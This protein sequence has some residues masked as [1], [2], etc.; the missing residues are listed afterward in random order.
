MVLGKTHPRFD[1]HKFF[2][3]YPEAFKLIYRQ[4]DFMKYRIVEWDNK[5]PSDLITR[6]ELELK[7]EK[8]QAISTQEQRERPVNE[9][10]G[11]SIKVPMDISSFKNQAAAT[12]VQMDRV[13]QFPLIFHQAYKYLYAFYGTQAII[14]CHPINLLIFCTFINGFEKF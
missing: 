12:E 14:Y 9:Q 11:N 13:T 10:Q 4:R 2:K 8:K 1:C 3:T 5:N 6:M 7:A